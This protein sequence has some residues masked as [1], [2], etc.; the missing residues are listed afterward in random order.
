MTF[1]DRK[2]SVDSLAALGAASNKSLTEIREEN[3]SPLKDEAPLPGTTLFGF[4][5][6]ATDQRFKDFVRLIEYK[7]LLSF[8]AIL[9]S[10]MIENKYPKIESMFDNTLDV[11]ITVLNTLEGINNRNNDSNFY[12]IP[13][14][15]PDAAANSGMDLDLMSLVFNLLIKMLAN[16]SDPTWKTPWFLPGP[17]TPFG[18][19][20]KILEAIADGDSDSMAEVAKGLANKQAEID[21]KECSDEGN[22]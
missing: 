9:V 8:I 11:L 16:M 13:S 6:I 17:L 7:P 12:Q 20:A 18:I 3:G 14:I 19:I 22:S 1:Y 4:N 10:E 15:D 21:N 2:N 5:L